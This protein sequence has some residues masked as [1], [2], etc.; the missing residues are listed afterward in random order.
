[1]PHSSIEEQGSSFIKRVLCSLLIAAL[2]F[3]GA[4]A[5]TPK[6]KSAKAT[7]V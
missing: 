5:Q 3:G 1:M 4:L 2:P 7:L 6:E